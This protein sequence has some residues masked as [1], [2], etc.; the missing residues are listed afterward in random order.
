MIKHQI[1]VNKH[2]PVQTQRKVNFSKS[3]YSNAIEQKAQYSPL[4]NNLLGILR[5]LQVNFFKKAPLDDY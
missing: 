2:L 5:K 1:F 4:S 3:Y